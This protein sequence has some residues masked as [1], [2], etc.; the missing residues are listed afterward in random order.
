[1]KKTLF[2]GLLLSFNTYSQTEPT[3]EEIPAVVS[4]SDFDVIHEFPF[5]QVYTDGDITIMAALEGQELYELFEPAFQNYN[6]E[7]S[8]YTWEGVIIQLLK[9]KNKEL[10]K[11]L[12]FRSEAGGFYVDVDSEETANKFL[13]VVCPYFKDA[14]TL[15]KALKGIDKSKIDD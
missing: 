15:D 9:K 4:E 11:H 12:Y 1:M 5:V 10:L 3:K 13:D 7:G 8:G 2:F 6:F 14:E